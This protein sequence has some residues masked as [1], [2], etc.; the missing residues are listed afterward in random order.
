MAYSVLVRRAGH[1][2]LST[3]A[4]CSCTM[5]F[6]H[7]HVH[8]YKRVQ[9]NSNTTKGALICC[10]IYLL[11][12]CGWPRWG[13]LGLFYPALRVRWAA[14]WTFLNLPGAQNMIRGLPRTR[15]QMPACPGD[16]S[17][18]KTNEPGAGPA[19]TAHFACVNNFVRGTHSR[20]RI[21]SQGPLHPHIHETIAYNCLS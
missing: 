18:K 10:F 19:P 1:Q 9:Y 20:I 11:G 12:P 3:P 4:L 8:I 14:H 5:V 6:A 13:N 2:W 21:P 16:E 7:V 17:P 15:P